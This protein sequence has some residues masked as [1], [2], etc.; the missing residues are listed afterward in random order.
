MKGFLAALVLSPL[1]LF[2][3]PVS[4]DTSSSVPSEAV[5]SQVTLFFDESEAAAVD[6]GYDHE[7]SPVVWIF[8]AIGVSALVA[9]GVLVYVNRE[10]KP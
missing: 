1:F 6:D 3:L 2:A 10:D 5:S 4:A 7:A 9:S 8:I